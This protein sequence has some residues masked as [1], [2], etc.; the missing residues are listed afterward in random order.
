MSEKPEKEHLTLKW[1]TLKAWEFHSSKAKK[2]L[3][4][5]HEIGASLSV[6]MQKDTP[7]QKK[8][9]CELIDVGNFKKVYLDW[10]GKYVSKEKAKKY[11]WGMTYP[12][13]KE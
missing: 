2:L 9:I 4:E 5:Y 1:G 6:A 12:K 3:E 10:D 11:V 13:D 8:I 7:R